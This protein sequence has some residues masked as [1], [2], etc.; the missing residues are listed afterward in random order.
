ML[1]K[2]HIRTPQTFFGVVMLASAS[3]QWD[4]SFMH[5]KQTAS[6]GYEYDHNFTLNILLTL[7]EQSLSFEP[8]HLISNNVICATSKASDQ[9]AHTHSLIRAFVIRLNII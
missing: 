9:P 3:S 4:N 2:N 1:T 6:D 7:T 8:R 5:T